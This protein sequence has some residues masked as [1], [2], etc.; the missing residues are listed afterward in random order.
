MPVRDGSAQAL[1][2]GRPAV[3]AG[4]VGRGPRL[5]DEH[6]P[7]RI[8]VELALEPSLPFAQDVCSLLLG[9][10]R[11]LFLSVIRR[12]SKKRHRRP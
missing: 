5:V 4:H 9:R 7:G 6:Q 2:S 1:A 3:G 10:V 11:G 12:R 8:E